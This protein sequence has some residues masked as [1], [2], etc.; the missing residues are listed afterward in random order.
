MYL[1]RECPGLR[2]HTAEATGSKPVTPTTI[3]AGQTA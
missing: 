2:F 1:G 3:F